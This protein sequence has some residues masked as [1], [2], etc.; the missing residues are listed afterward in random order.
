[1]CLRHLSFP[2]MQWVKREVLQ[3]EVRTL[4][5]LRSSRMFKPERRVWSRNVIWAQR[6]RDRSVPCSSQ[7]TFIRCHFPFSYFM[8]I[9]PTTFFLYVYVN[10]VL[11]LLLHHF[12]SVLLLETVLTTLYLLNSFSHNTFE[13]VYEGNANN[14]LK[15]IVINNI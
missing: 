6:S 9:S 2:W 1:M 15:Q 11:N 4:A 3:D 10:I 14:K 8:W 7:E 12:K 13:K 5:R